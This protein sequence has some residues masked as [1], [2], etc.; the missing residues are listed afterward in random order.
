VHKGTSLINTKH[1]RT[2]YKS[3]LKSQICQ[4]T[5]VAIKSDTYLQFTVVKF[6]VTVATEKINHII[7]LESGVNWKLDICRAT[8]SLGVAAT[9]AFL[10]IFIEVIICARPTGQPCKYVSE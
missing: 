4:H 8:E 5:Y 9:D 10:A 2:N 6:L 7:M 1:Y 3:T